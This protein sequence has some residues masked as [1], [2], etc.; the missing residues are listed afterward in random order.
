MRRT[1]F[2]HDGGT[3]GYQVVMRFY[4]NY[5]ERAKVAVEA[6]RLMLE[7]TWHGFGQ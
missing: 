7:V 3:K 1:I 5:S 4:D 6:A 2:E